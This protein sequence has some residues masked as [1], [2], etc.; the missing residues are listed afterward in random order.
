MDGV[1][2][3]FWSLPRQRRLNESILLCEDLLCLA[4]HR[5]PEAQGTT[6]ERLVSSCRCS[7]STG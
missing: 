6:K 7:M 1:I 5:L 3:G 2:E 4:S